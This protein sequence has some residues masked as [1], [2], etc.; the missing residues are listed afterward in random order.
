MNFKFQLLKGEK[1]SPRLGVFETPHGKVTTPHF[2]PVATRGLM[3]GPWTNRLQ[4]MGVEM[5]LANS[6]HLFARPGVDV[7]NKLGKLHKA[8]AWDG[9]ILTDSGGFQAFSLENVKIHDKGVQIPHPVHGAKVD[10]TPKLAFEVQEQLAPDVA[11]LLDVCPPDPRD[12]D[13]V[14]LAVRRTLNWAQE[15]RRYHE[16]RGGTE[17]G[18]AQFGIVQGGVFPDLREA[19]ATEL[20]NLDFDGYAVGGV[21]VGEGHEAM[22]D[23][24]RFSTSL[25]PKDKIRYLMGVGTP[26]DLVESVARGIDIFDCVYPTRSGRYGTFMTDEGMQHIHNAAFTEDPRPLME[27]CTCDACTSGLSRAMLRAGMKEREILAA[28][29]LAHHNVHYLVKLMERIR[30]A[31]AEGTFEELRAVI[32]KHY[33]KKQN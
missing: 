12:R 17:S 25:L 22:M 27:G 6:F 30:K 24:V 26:L 5:I 16:D 2:M 3:R 13:D 31:I 33:A 10:W 32:N 8:M 14:A 7:I 9:P 18:Q 29:M 1:S 11:M 15:Q 20:C 21:S 28:S 19:C 4:P 23:G